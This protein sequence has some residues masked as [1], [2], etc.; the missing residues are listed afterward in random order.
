MKKLLLTV[1][2]LGGVLFASQ[3]SYA[4]MMVVDQNLGD[5]F[6]NPDLFNPDNPTIEEAWL[7][8]LLN[9][10]EPA[11]PYIDVIYLFKAE[12]GVNG[13]V[14][15]NPNSGVFTYSPGVDWDYAVMKLGQGQQAYD[16]IA[17]E[18]IGNNTFSFDFTNFIDEYGRMQGV[19]HITFFDG[20]SD[21]DP[22]PEPATMLLFGTGLVGLAGI[23]RRKVR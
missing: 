9:D 11:T 10:T 6:S 8:N 17:F 14:F 22:V 23:A 20:P 12:S 13:V 5:T 2:A 16:H 21:G 15:N 3:A 18:N 4:A 1:L 7:E 19:S